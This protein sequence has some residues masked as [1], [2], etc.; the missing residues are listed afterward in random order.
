M[1]L[2]VSGGPIRASLEVAS[3]IPSQ[4]WKHF[5]QWEKWRE[6]PFAS[7]VALEK[8]LSLKPP[9]RVL[10]TFFYC[11]LLPISAACG[12]GEPFW[13][14]TEGLR[15]NVV[16]PQSC[17]PSLFFSPSS[18]RFHHG[19][20]SPHYSCGFHNSPLKP[21]SRVASEWAAEIL[22]AAS[23]EPWPIEDH[24]G[25]GRENSSPYWSG[26]TTLLTFL[27]SDFLEAQL[28]PKLGR[29]THTLALL[30]EAANS[31]SQLLFKAS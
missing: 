5:N 9:S 7:E 25:V 10:V 8:T 29:Q 21:E 18:F 12:K 20:T 31:H 1:L 19:M 30:W 11:S 17:S 13:F 22:V 4:S 28:W 16:E 14:H 26:D 24:S 6:T 27:M 23:S 15:M 3:M 2:L